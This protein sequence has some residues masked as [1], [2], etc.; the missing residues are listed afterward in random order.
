MTMRPY[1]SVGGVCGSSYG[2]IS[3]CYNTGRVSGNNSDVGG[4]C[5]YCLGETTKRTESY[6][7]YLDTCAVKVLAILRLP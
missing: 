2:T 1:G 5:G 6:C 3:N 4:V 7:Y